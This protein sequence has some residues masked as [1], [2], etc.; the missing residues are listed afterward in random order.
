MRAQRGQ[1]RGGDPSL[2]R[3]EGTMPSPP[4]PRGPGASAWRGRGD[5]AP[6][7]GEAGEG[8]GR[9]AEGLQPECCVLEVES[10][11]RGETGGNRRVDVGR[12][13]GGDVRGPFAVIKA[14]VDLEREITTPAKE[15]LDRL[16]RHVG[17]QQS[18]RDKDA[19]RVD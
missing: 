13:R 11:E 17:R 2:V 8:L 1:V 15:A 16:T 4:M 12:V 6:A 7:R 19:E 9:R 3:R 5:L 18:A 14:R 10:A